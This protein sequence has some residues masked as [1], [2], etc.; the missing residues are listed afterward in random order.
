MDTSQVKRDFG[1]FHSSNVEELI[2]LNENDYKPPNYDINLDLELYKNLELYK[3]FGTSDFKK[4]LFYLT[5]EFCF[6]NHGAFGLTFK[7]VISYI[8]KWKEFAES[9]P[10][11]FYD[12]LVMP[13]LVDVIRK[14]SNEILHCKPNEL[15]LVDNCTFAFNSII[16][17]IK[18][19]PGDK[20]FMFSTTYGVYKKILRVKCEESNGT[21]I[22]AQ[23][24][25]PIID[26]KD[27]LNKFVSRL[28]EILI[29]DEEKKIK[30]VFVDHIPSN[31]PFLVPILELSNLC[32]SIRSDIVF[33]VDAAHSLGSVNNFDLRNYPNIDFLFGNCH[34][35]LCGP[36]GTAFLYK[37]SNIK[38]KF[39]LIPA[40]QSH[41]INSG[42]NSE[43]I[44]SGL[45]D[46]SI[47]LG[48][49][50]TFLIWNECL[51]GLSNAIKYSVDLMKEA[52]TYLKSVW[53][54]DFL[55]HPDLCS[56]MICVKLPK[57]F[58]HNVI[59]LHK[60]KNTKLNDTSNLSKLNYDQAELVQNFF[61]FSYKIEV[62]IKCIQ[63]E[64]YVRISC[65]IYNNINDYTKLAD[66]VLEN[67][68]ILE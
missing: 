41:G 25:F 22:E 7:P 44:W 35:W 9:Q 40:V 47:Y 15:V 45:K 67:M 56:T 57:K 24:Q 62:P 29:N 18:L 66:A 3:R 64:L 16:N 38:E 54:S 14:F 49:Y 23:I 65:H 1:S 8:N 12:R 61:Y 33:I 42:F 11:R 20:V 31:Q 17:S 43:F 36:K 26:E 28:K 53:S 5:D 51:G 68:D 55:V 63:N 30:V 2:N 19:D 46:Y 59:L 34:K 10:L 58:V 21:L 13:L 4:T 60:L 48:L 50:A 52:G 32:K 37:N 6:L 39:R 27:L